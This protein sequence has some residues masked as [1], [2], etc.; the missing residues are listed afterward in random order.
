MYY[1]E[2]YDIFTYPS[3]YPSWS[4]NLDELT[5]EPPISY[6]TDTLEDG[7]FYEWN[8]GVQKWIVTNIPNPYVDPNGDPLY[9][10]EHY[11]CSWKQ[12]QWV[13]LPIEPVGIA[14]T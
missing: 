13:L 5:W 1:H 14:S 9:D 3:P 11:E 7:E 6:P 10:Q 4:F 8:E 12:I 2:E